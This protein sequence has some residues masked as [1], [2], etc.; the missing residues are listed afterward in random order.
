MSGS[1]FGDAIKGS[2]KNIFLLMMAEGGERER[3]GTLKFPFYFSPP[4]SLPL[5]SLLLPAPTLSLLSGAFTV[6]VLEGWAQ[7]AGLSGVEGVTLHGSPGLSPLGLHFAAFRTIPGD[8]TAANS[9]PRRAIW[10]SLFRRAV[11][12]LE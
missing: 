3:K 4:H 11:W 10:V 9:H 1:A 6:G 2:F 12:A 8:P 5:L 7:R